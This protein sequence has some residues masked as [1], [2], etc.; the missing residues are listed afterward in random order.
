MHF[1]EILNF[2][3]YSTTKTAVTVLIAYSEEASSRTEREI[4][5]A[6]HQTPRP[7]VY[8]YKHNTKLL[9]NSNLPTPNPE[10]FS[11]CKVQR[12]TYSNIHSHA[13]AQHNILLHL[14]QKYTDTFQGEPQIVMGKKVSM[15][16][17][18]VMDTSLSFATYLI[19]VCPAH[20]DFKM[21]VC[22]SVWTSWYRNCAPILAYHVAVARLQC[23]LHTSR[24]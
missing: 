9:S 10:G 2:F 7:V 18:F 21:A 16:S 5:R 3:H 4:V 12:M 19:D 20:K 15:H 24:N 14:Q 6:V 8:I 11:W 1:Y 13:H 22:Q 23:S 17:K